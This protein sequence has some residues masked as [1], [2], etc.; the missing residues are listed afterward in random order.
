MA[1]PTCEH[2]HN[3][4]EAVTQGHHLLH[5]KS[6]RKIEWWEASTQEWEPL[7]YNKCADYSWDCNCKQQRFP[8]WFWFQSSAD[9]EIHALWRQE[10]CVEV[11]KQLLSPCAVVSHSGSTEFTHTVLGLQRVIV[12]KSNSLLANHYELR[13]SKPSL[14]LKLPGDPLEI[15]QSGLRRKFHSRGI[16]RWILPLLEVRWAEL[17]C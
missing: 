11:F 7:L 8:A 2:H 12:C 13:D 3:L 10:N 6:V 17:M 4:F 15:H 16:R 14:K 5:S 1:R 9:L